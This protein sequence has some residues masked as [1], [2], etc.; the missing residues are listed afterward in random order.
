M[1]S[2]LPYIKFQDLKQEYSNYLI[3]IDGVILN[4]K[5]LI[6]SA[7]IAFQQLLNDKEKKCFIVT[8]NSCYTREELA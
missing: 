1:E 5:E 2:G 8:N 4:D 7:G 3:D 6:E